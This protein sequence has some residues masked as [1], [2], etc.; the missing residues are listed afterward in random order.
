MSGPPI[1]GYNLS[2]DYA[3]LYN[4]ILSE[5]YRVPAWL[6]DDGRWLI[7]EVKAGFGEGTMIGVIGHSYGFGY[8]GYDEFLMT[9]KGYNLHFVSPNA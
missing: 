5:K 6:L 9:C 4:L 8:G 3:L 1:K 2:T 7:V